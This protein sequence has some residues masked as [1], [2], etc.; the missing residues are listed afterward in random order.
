VRQQADKAPPIRLRGDVDI[1]EPAP[2]IERFGK[3]RKLNSLV[4]VSFT[5]QLEKPN[6][7][8]ICFDQPSFKEDDFDLLI[9]QKVL[10]ELGPCSQGNTISGFICVANL[11]FH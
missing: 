8:V 7:S 6:T 11:A 9:R 3:R 2:S 4:P 1:H 5:T 10:L